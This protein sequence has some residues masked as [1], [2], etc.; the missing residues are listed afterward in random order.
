MEKK[1]ML[2]L[3]SV[4]RAKYV[5]KDVARPTDVLYAPK[6]APG[7][8]LYLKTENLQV[9]SSIFLIRLR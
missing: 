1:D 5:L 4:Y 7:T 8:E 6:L 3:D 2:T 9:L